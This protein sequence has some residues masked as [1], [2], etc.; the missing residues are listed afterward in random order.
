MLLLLFIESSAGCFSMFHCVAG[1]SVRSKLQ[2]MFISVGDSFHAF[3][4]L[5]FTETSQML[6][7][8]YSCN[9]LGF[10]VLVR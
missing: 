3:T 10:V 1:Q 5:G 6:S 2:C 8:F 4:F 9:C 7:A